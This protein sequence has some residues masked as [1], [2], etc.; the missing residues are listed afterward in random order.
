MCV[1][2]YFIDHDPNGAF[3]GPNEW[4]KKHFVKKWN[5]TGSR[6]VGFEH[7]VQPRCWTW[8]IYHRQIQWVAGWNPLNW[9]QQINYKP[10]TLTTSSPL[11]CRHIPDRVG[12]CK[13][14]ARRIQHSD[15]MQWY[16]LLPPNPTA[17]STKCRDAWGDRCA[18]RDNSPWKSP[19]LLWVVWTLWGMKIFPFW[20]LQKACNFRCTWLHMSWYCIATRSLTCE[21][22]YP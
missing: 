7:K 21:C 8:H 1:N 10:S 3:Q 11:L 17:L 5:L 14:A 2:V 13:E 20:N 19:L 9:D 16:H 6:P 18:W 22:P 15:V 4:L 12:W